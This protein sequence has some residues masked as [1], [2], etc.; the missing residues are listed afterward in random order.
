MFENN[1][2]F[3]ILENLANYRLDKALA[4]ISELSR[5]KLKEYIENGFV[6]VDNKTVNDTNYKVKAG[7][8]VNI[9][10]P[11]TPA[12]NMDP[13]ELK[14]DIRY[15][16]EHLLVLNKP[17]GLT[18]HPGAGNYSDTLANALI[19]H[20]GK[21]LSNIGG[22][23]RPGIVH[24]LDKDTTGLMVVAKNNIAHASLSE[25]ISNRNLKRIYKTLVWGVPS[26]LESKI[27]TNI[28]R[29]RSDRTKM[30]VL[31]IGGKEAIT[32]YKVEEILAS[33]Q[34]SLVECRLQTGR[35]HQIRVHMS[36]IGHSVVGD[37]VY[38]HNQRKITKYFTGDQQLALE[39]FKRQALHSAYIAFDHPIK[40][41]FLEFSSDLPEDMDK[42][43]H[44][45]KE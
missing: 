44:K 42:L 7:Q 1:Y 28:G 33:G 3:I 25:Q 12:T 21:E 19:Y 36:H 16:D 45:I 2:T 29:S 34:L 37:Q 8:L 17:A 30:T 18:V 31:S 9:N 13:F 23:E 20:F 41:S 27:A 11:P 15:E 14:L 4:E 22:T 10:I 5:T 39:N 40:G 35:T 43:I 38:G 26:P 6:R 32:F 24:R